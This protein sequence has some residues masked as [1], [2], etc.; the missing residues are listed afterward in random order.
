MACLIR[1]RLRDETYLYYSTSYRDPTNGKVKNKR[2][3]I[4]KIDKKTGQPIYK[5]ECAHLIAELGLNLQKNVPHENN[6]ENMEQPKIFSK[7]DLLN[8][9]IKSYGSYR[10]LSEISEKIGLIKILQTVFSDKWQNI[11]TL[12]FYL[13]C[14][15]DPVLYCEKW[16]ESTES[17]VSSGSMASQRISE[18][19]A[20]ILPSQINDFYCGWSKYRQENEY[21]ALDITSISSYSNLIENVEWG[22]NRDG[23]KLPQIN[24][25]LLYGENSGLPIY[26]L[27]YSGSLKDV[28]TLTTTLKQFKML[29]N[30][31]VF[32]IVTDKGFYSKKNINNLLN[33]NSKDFKFVM[34]VP[35]NN[36]LAKNLIEEYTKS[37]SD[38]KKI[39]NSIAIGNDVVYGETTKIPWVNEKVTTEL[40]CHIYYNSFNAENARRNL[41]SCV[42]VLEN[43]ANID[44]ENCKLKKE[45]QKYL[46]F[47]KSKKSNS[48]Y[49]VQI[50][51]T[52]IEK[53]L[54]NSGWLILFSNHITDKETAL[55]IYRNKDVVE[56]G[57]LRLKNNL[58]L[59]R[60]RVH[61][62]RNTNSKLFVAFI[63][64]II[65]SHIHKV[66]I[67]HNFYKSMTMKDLI[68]TVEKL[69]VVTIKGERIEYPLT[70][71]QK[72]IF[73]AFKIEPIL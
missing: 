54:I 26:S 29:N 55:S 66:M 50:N 31:I 9:T 67:D 49:T 38:L 63:S 39:D 57:F 60:L 43:E 70:K 28:S 45:Y 56:K 61:S 1:Q 72:M 24:F 46:I 30:G 5:S 12:A 15:D 42:K 71:E 25:C 23:E 58:G 48:G 10:L 14:E 22:Y 33:E 7:S 34:A 21:L 59:Y 27:S 64:L 16:I 73:D 19:L 37:I 11:L 17:I 69:L 52:V 36:N 8:S 32:Q 3:I 44:P 6:S 18:L 13:V 4:G 2:Q 51:A 65:M 62:D 41:I 53:E 20:K 47:K 40:Y 68:K 35:V